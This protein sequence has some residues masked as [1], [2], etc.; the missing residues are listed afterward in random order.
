MRKLND[1]MLDEEVGDDEKLRRRRRELRKKTHK[2]VSLPLLTQNF[3][4]LSFWHWI[5]RMRKRLFF[6]DWLEKSSAE[7]VSFSISKTSF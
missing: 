6:L 3:W 1:W 5:E 4:A 7:I 2:E